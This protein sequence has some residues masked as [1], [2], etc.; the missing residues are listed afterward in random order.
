MR[1]ITL[2]AA[3]AALAISGSA[4]ASLD[5]TTMTLSLNHAGGFSGPSALNNATYTYGTTTSYAVPGWGSFNAISPMGAAGYEHSM[6]LDLTAFSYSAF[7]GMFATTGT[8][9]LT[10]LAEAADVSSVQVL[11]NGMSAGTG[12]APVGNGFA[13]SWNTQT[14]F[15]A[16]PINPSVTVAWNSV[17]GPG[18]LALLGVAGLVA[19]SRKRRG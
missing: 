4:F 5:G 19:R 12:V 17:P 11:I 8:L 16:N 15:N 6:K 10:G 13:A 9:K 2:S 14:V 1:K 3:A 7:T 18:S